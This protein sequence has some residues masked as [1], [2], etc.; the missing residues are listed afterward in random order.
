MVKIAGIQM[1]CC[2]D[3]EKN[4]QK[5][6]RLASLAAEQGGNII[7]FQVLTGTHWFPMDI[8]PENFQLAEEIPGPTTETFQELALRLGSVI[9]LPLFEKDP[10]GAFFNSAVI[11]DASGEIL[12]KYRKVHIP[13]IPLW[14]EKAYFQPG[15]LGFPV[16]PTRYG[17]VGVQICWDN[18]FP[19]GSRIL[20]LKG[21]QIIFSPTAAAFNSQPKWEKVIC[22]NAATNGV[23]I[24]RV[25]RVGVEGKQSFY[26]KSFCATPDG[27]LG[28]Q[29]SGSQEGIVIVEIDLQEIERTRRVW[30][31]FRDRRPELY[32]ELVRNGK[33]F[34]ALPI[35]SEESSNHE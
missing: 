8:N 35:D 10:G 27:D 13:Q 24:F 23:Y 14:E 21:A 22:A 2:R 9:I 26:G 1:S 30:T 20:A 18:F 33:E 12:G 25:N 17:R 16:F 15:D 3:K 29:P 7:C 5:A 28:D 6:L 11:I 4:L 34:T 32:G 31:F 19:E